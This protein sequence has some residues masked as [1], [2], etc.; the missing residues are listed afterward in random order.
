MLK[1]ETRYAIDPVSARSFGTDGLRNN[2]LVDEL[3][4]EGEIKLVYTHYDRLILGSVVPSGKQLVLDQ[5]PETGTETFLERRE[6]GILNIG[7][8]GT[9]AVDDKTYELGEGEVLYIGMG[10]GAVTF[11]GAGRFYILSAPAHKAYPT[12][13]VRISDAR[14]IEL[15]SPEQANERVI[16]Q[17][18]HPE[19][20]ESCQLVMGYTQLAE[21]SVWNTMPVHQHDRRMEAYLYFDLK[22]AD[23]VFHLMG[24]PD[25]TR[26]I[27][28]ANEQAVVSPSW[29]IHSGAGTGSYTFCWGMA[30]DNVDFGDM[31]VVAM[32]VLR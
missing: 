10:S 25:N 21:G 24:E 5:M 27:V 13:L 29:S 17:L 3:F 8:I 23:R 1:T 30:G 14:R 9:V 7:E 20:I 32:D 15:G 22:A 31:D 28:V 18:I 16:I 12:K 11:S 26:H 4:V 19:V 2:F 6:L